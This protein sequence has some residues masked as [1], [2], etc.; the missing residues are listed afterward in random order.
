MPVQKIN[1][2]AAPNDKTG[3]SLREAFAL[4]NAAIDQVNANTEAIVGKVDK[5]AGMGLSQNSFTNEQRDK[6]NGLEGSHWRG[7]FLSVSALQAALPTAN[8]GDYADVDTGVGS[9]VQRYIWD[10]SDA[11]WVQQGAATTITAAQV[12]ALYESNA[13]TKAFTDAEES[14]LE[15]IAA[16]ATRVESKYIDCTDLKDFFTQCLALGSGFYR[17]NEGAVPEELRY[18]H[19]YFSTSNSGTW[20]FTAN[21]YTSG[22]PMFY[23]GLTGDIAAGTWK[24]YDPMDR[25][26]HTGTQAISTVNGLQAWMT[27][28]TIIKSING[29][30]LA[31]IRNKVINGG[32]RIQQRPYTSGAATT[33]GQYVIDRWKVTGTQGVTIAN[34]GGVVTLTI[35][36]GQTLQQV[37]EGAN[38]QGGAYVLSWQGTA[39]GRIGGGAYGASGAVSANIVGGANTTIE[40]NAGTVTAIQLELGSVGQNTQYEHPIV[41]VELLCCQRYY[42][43]YSGVFALVSVGY[44]ANVNSK[45][46]NVPMRTIPTIRQNTPGGTGAF[47]NA[48][49]STVIA[50]N[51]VHSI[52]AGTSIL[53]LEAEL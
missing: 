36:A 53:E 22:K 42:Q 33:A 8:A 37:I 18:A 46:L 19:G 29:G 26:N 12:K 11:K 48:I 17:A 14:K 3:D 51:G 34:A 38:L 32:F 9:D 49:T 2:G 44:A 16:G 45:V 52:D 24:Q 41:G 35:P 30:Q 27:N 23:A 20:S 6:L 13:N 28:P 15:S 39:Q 1:I 10:V 25:A 21:S 43:N 50:Q 47:W 4:T 5:A 31:G 7:T 40:F